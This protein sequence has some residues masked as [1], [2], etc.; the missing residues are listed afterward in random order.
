MKI[1]IR[2]AVPYIHV[3]IMKFGDKTEYLSFDDTNSQEVQ[4]MVKK[5]IESQN[6]SVFDTGKKTQVIIR[7]YIGS[8]AGKSVSISFRGL[9][10]SKTK[11]LI[12]NYINSQK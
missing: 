6:L 12:L 10:P 4:D 8:K 5:V 3:S 9:S 7:E 2:E 1:R 11:E